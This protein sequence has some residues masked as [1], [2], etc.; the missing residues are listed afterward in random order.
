MVHIISTYTAY[1]QY[2]KSNLFSNKMATCIHVKRMKTENG[3]GKTNKKHN[4]VDIKTKYFGKQFDNRR[5]QCVWKL[6]SLGKYRQES[7]QTD[8]KKW[9]PISFNQR[10]NIRRD[11]ET[12]LEFWRINWSFPYL[13]NRKLRKYPECRSRKLFLCTCGAISR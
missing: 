3:L 8:V 6:G 2:Y 1:T 9:K 10:H 4:S 5:N 13:E 7:L 12:N 11:Q